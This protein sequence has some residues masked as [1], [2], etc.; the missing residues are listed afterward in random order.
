VSVFTFARTLAQVLL[1]KA[2][3]D[4][5]IKK[6]KS[7]VKKADAQYEVTVAMLKRS[8]RCKAR[9]TLKMFALTCCLVLFV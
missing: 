5:L 7:M 4:G 8:S 3:T 1:T 6:L 9:K 2:Q